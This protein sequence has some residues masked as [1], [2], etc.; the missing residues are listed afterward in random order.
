M[1]HVEFKTCMECQVYW[2]V[3]LVQLLLHRQDL[4]LKIPLPKNLSSRE[5]EKTDL[6]LNKVDIR[7]QLLESLLVLP[8]CLEP[9]QDLSHQ[10]LAEKFSI[11]LMMKNTGMNATTTFH[12]RRRM[13]MSKISFLIANVKLFSNICNPKKAERT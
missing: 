6:F 2:E 10:E 1:T 12:L 7:S 11:S 5:L 3:L 8:F 13:R 4:Y 9:F